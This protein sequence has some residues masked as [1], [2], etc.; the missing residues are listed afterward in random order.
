MIVR[1][2][3]CRRTSPLSRKSKP[4]T[5][6]GGP[7]T[8]PSAVPQS[9]RFW[10]SRAQRLPSEF[11]ATA[12]PMTKRRTELSGRI[13]RSSRAGERPTPA[14]LLRIHVLPQ[15]F[16][17]R[18]NHV[19]IVE[20]GINAPQGIALECHFLRGAEI[21]ALHP[22]EKHMLDRQNEIVSRDEVLF[23]DARRCR[24]DVVAHRAVRT[25][26]KNAAS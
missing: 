8:A 3:L 2:V 14:E 22:I 7:A 23:D 16:G 18:R 1:T 6:G 17:L 15:L 21:A 19:P 13:R 4:V 11:F 25:A 10:S 5:E 24:R 26:N 12:W 20:G 9:S